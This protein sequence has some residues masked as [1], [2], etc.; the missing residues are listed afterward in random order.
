MTTKTTNIATPQ[1]GKEKKWL[2]EYNIWFYA[3]FGTAVGAGTLFL[4][5]QLGLSGPLAMLVMLGLLQIIN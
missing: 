4:P 2:P 5:V 3:L 1:A